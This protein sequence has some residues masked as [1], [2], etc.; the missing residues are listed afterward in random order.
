MPE[1]ARVLGAPRCCPYTGIVIL[2]ICQYGHPVLRQRG[3][4]IKDIT[5]ATRQLATDMIET[6][7]AANGV[8]LAAQQVGQALTLTV[9]DVSPTDLPWSG[10][11][12][13]GS[14]LEMPLVLVNPQ[15]SSPTGEQLGEEGCLSIPEITADISRAEQV[16]VS[17]TDLQGQQILFTCTGLLAR[18]VQHEL[19]HLDGILF[20]DRMDPATRASLAGKLKRMQKETLARLKKHEKKR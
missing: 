4:A 20:T 15:I 2:D 11:K 3:A 17:A 18:A 12:A 1:I 10:Q 6:M 16:T 9:I 5:D 13:D 7:Y 19:D 8:G 14:H